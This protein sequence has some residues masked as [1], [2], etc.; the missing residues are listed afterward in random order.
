L[1][2]GSIQ[3]WEALFDEAYRV[4]KPGG[5]LESHEASPMSYCDDGSIPEGSAIAQWGKFFFEGGK[6][7]GRTFKVI[8]NDIQPKNMERLGMENVSMFDMK[9][10]E[11]LPN[12][13][14]I[15]MCTGRLTD[16]ARLH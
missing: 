7:L 4:L 6:K 5:W 9:V 1:L 11:H 14:D 3:D 13:L 12:Q 16:F 8:E 2:Y 15:H 10:S